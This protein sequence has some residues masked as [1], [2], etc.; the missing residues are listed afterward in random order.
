MTPPPKKEQGHS[1]R[2]QPL[3][4]CPPGEQCF[5]QDPGSSRPLCAR[6][7]F[8]YDENWLKKSLFCP[9]RSGNRPEND[10][11]AG[12]EGLPL[13]VSLRARTRGGAVV[14][15]GRTSRCLYV[16]I[17]SPGRASPAVEYEDVFHFYPC[18]VMTGRGTYLSPPAKIHPGACDPA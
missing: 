6:R 10:F 18:F 9:F 1:L 15:A 8:V 2:A 16:F 11:F 7:A 4:G 17:D 14:L 3:M 13:P 5:S 12:F